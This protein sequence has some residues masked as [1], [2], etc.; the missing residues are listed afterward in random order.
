[1]NMTKEFSQSKAAS[2]GLIVFVVLFIIAISAIFSSL[3]AQDFSRADSALLINATD[4]TYRVY[5]QYA[6]DADQQAGY[7]T[8][9]LDSVQAANLLFNMLYDAQLRVYVQSA[10]LLFSAPQV[11]ALKQDIDAALI[12]LTGRNYLQTAESRYISE[13]APPQP[14]GQNEGFYSFRQGATTKILRIRASGAVR[15]VT[16]TGATVAGGLQGNIRIWTG[17]QRIE[18]VFNAGPLNGSSFDFY[19]LPAKNNRARWATTDKGTFLIRRKAVGD[20]G[21]N[22]AGLAK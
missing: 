3:K 16:N 18:I 8:E 15:E 11:T 22:A 10:Q 21:A 7:T 20:A 4:S 1:M 17:L 13:L 9:Q 2:W 6:N 14:N 19:Q 12:A 5:T